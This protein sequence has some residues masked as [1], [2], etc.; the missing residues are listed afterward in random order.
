M[1]CQEDLS[2]A[3]FRGVSF[4]VSKDA[5]AYGRRIATHEYPNRDIPFH[6]DLGQKNT[7]VKVSAYVFEPGAAGKAQALVAACTTEGAG[8]LVLPDGQVFLCVAPQIERTREREKNGYRAFEIEFRVDGEQT[9]FGALGVFGRL[10]DDIGFG[11]PGIL[12]DALSAAFIAPQLIGLIGT[13]FGVGQVPDF[14]RSVAVSTLQLAAGELLGAVEAARL[15]ETETQSA[16]RALIGATR[17]AERVF[18]PLLQTFTPPDT[19]SRNPLG[20]NITDALTRLNLVI[21]QVGQSPDPAL[22]DQVLKRIQDFVGPAPIDNPRAPSE[23]LHNAV[24]DGFQAAVRR[25][26]LVERSRLAAER[27]FASRRDAVQLRADLAEDYNEHLEATRHLD[28]LYEAL[29]QARNL[30]A[31]AVSR[32]VTNLAPVLTIEAPRSMPALYW[33]WRLYQD[34]ERAAE[35]VRRNGVR[36]AS[37]M[38]QEFEALAR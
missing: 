22:A 19:G 18:D 32:R 9:G 35:L 12:G 27:T 24:L 33:A 26:A 7:T 37:L 6:E 38:P 28:K 11:L 10:I 13:P 14:V 21:R 3:S 20:G 2:A 25:L 16:V 4:Y 31:Q 1:L 30:A 15:P 36:H 23:R 17:T 34:P 8:L 5:V 29:V